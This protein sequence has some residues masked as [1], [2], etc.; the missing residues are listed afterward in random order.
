[1]KPDKV[2]PKKMMATNQV[3]KAPR[4]RRTR[5]ARRVVASPRRT[6]RKRRKRRSRNSLR[7]TMSSMD[8]SVMLNLRILMHSK[9][10]SAK[11]SENS[12]QNQRLK[13]PEKPSMNLS[14]A[15]PLLMTW[16]RKSR[17]A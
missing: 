9:K 13:K 16:K 15:V 5:R 10:V 4:T 17:R 8:Q 2:P 14:K 12:C 3:V 6:R 1:M 11:S 7:R